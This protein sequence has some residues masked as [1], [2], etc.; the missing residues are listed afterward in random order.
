MVLRIEFLDEGIRLSK[1]SEC[2]THQL[3][4]ARPRGGF[5]FT[6]QTFSFGFA[7]KELGIKLMTHLKI[8][9]T[10]SCSVNSSL[11]ISPYSVSFI[12]CLNTLSRQRFTRVPNKLLQSLTY[13]SDAVEELHEC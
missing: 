13:N 10:P 12:P 6:K 7:H 11:S 5:S 9:V 3:R 8:K 2:R 1:Q 4:M